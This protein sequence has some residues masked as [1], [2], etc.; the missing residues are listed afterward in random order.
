MSGRRETPDGAGIGRSYGELY[1]EYAPAARGLALSMVPP[2]VADDIVAE[3]FARVLAA[4]RAGGGPD[5]AFRPYLLAAVRN[6]ANDWIAARRR[7]TV[8]GDLD[9]EADDRSAP[10]ISGF[11]GDAATEAEARAEARLIVRAFSRLPERWRAVLWQLEV[12]G[13][14]PAEVAPVF[15]LSGNGVSALAMRAREGLRQAYLREHI[16][17][18]IPASCRAYAEDLGAGTRG[19]LSPR[20]QAAMQEHLGHCPAC[21]DLFTELSELNRKLGTILAPIALAG[22]SAALH[23]GR[24]V[25]RTGLAAHWR[26]MRWHPVTAATGAAASVA[27]AGGML[28]AVNVTPL[29]AAPS[30]GTVQ[31]ADPATNSGSPAGHHAGDRRGG[32]GG[33]AGGGGAGGTLTGSGT[34]VGGA[35]VGAAGL[36]PGP[37]SLTG[38]ASM[39]GAAPL[40]GAAPLADTM[41]GAVSGLTGTA[42]SAVTG[43][44]GATVTGLAGTVDTTVTGLTGTVNGTVGSLAGTAATTLTGTTS[45]V[46]TTVAGVTGTV[47]TTVNGL[48]NAAAATVTGVTSSTLATVSGVTGTVAGVTGTTAAAISGVTGTVGGTVAGTAS[49]VTA[50]VAG[51]ASTADS[52]ATDLAS[53]AAGAVTGTTSTVT[54]TADTAKAATTGT[55][56]SVAG[57]AA[58]PS[59]STA[60][61]TASPVSSPAAASPAAS[62]TST[63][64][65][66]AAGA[67]STATSAGS[68]VSGAVSGAT[69]AVGSTVSAGGTTAASTGG[70][71]T[72][73]VTGVVGAALG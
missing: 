38:V 15:G 1:V 51:V 29:P 6:L 44:A 69:T 71:V 12:E 8:I 65:T 10:L 73:A 19:R 70:A 26:A 18:N 50:T 32:G 39:N 21:Q 66:A 2:D 17:T 4:I 22:T 5:H 48:A 37:A 30:H 62:A 47:G 72:A 60:S 16:G 3:A 54:E 9:E 55:V 53:S 57:A 49:T 59:A 45:T 46:V 41:G 27:V 43:L 36:P 11:S 64:N 52:A 23:G 35:P 40:T 34:P 13:K 61:G 28:F 7:V 42:G 20:R 56:G 14:A 63:T 25:L 68:T 67:A 58:A 31:A 33:G 24:H